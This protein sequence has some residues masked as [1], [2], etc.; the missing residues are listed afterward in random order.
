MAAVRGPGKRRKFI[1]FWILAAFFLLLCWGIAKIRPGLRGSS[2]RPFSRINFVLLD[3][4]KQS[5]LLSLGEGKGEILFLPADLEVSVPGG[6]GIYRLGKIYSLGELEKRG[7][8]LLA[9]TLRANFEAAIFGS[10]YDQGKSREEYLKNPSGLFGEICRRVLGGQIKTSLKGYDLLVFCRRA[11]GLAKERVS[12]GELAKADFAD[13]RISEE[14][15]SLEVL[16]ATDHNNLALETAG[17]LEKAGGRVVRSADAPQTQAE[18]EIRVKEEAVL[19]YTLS[20][21]K[22][23]FPCPVVLGQEGSR[24]DISLFLGE[25]YWKKW[26]EE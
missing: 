21:I 15:L 25:N 11:V 10:F 5:L 24:A 4:Q 6:F 26:G 23:F 16:N 17:F 22:R 18:C 3:A 1:F 7:E 14:G 20:W 8:E 2:L 19:S 13:R 9:D 12:V